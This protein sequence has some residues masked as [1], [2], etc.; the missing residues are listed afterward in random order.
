MPRVAKDV[1][2]PDARGKKIVPPLLSY[3]SVFYEPWH[4][5]RARQI[6][7]PRRGVFSPRSVSITIWFMIIGQYA[8]RDFTYPSD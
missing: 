1:L 7:Q 3:A 6:A 4:L 2:F 8:A 5:I